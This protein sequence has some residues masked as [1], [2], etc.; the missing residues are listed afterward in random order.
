MDLF[1]N[2]FLNDPAASAL[3]L[4]GALSPR[5]VNTL[6]PMETLTKWHYAHHRA[7]REWENTI[8]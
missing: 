2:P 1:T 4:A 3:G 8:G 7:N 5:I 6:Y